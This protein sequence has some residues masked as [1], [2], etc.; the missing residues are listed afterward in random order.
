MKTHNVEPFWVV[1]KK[2]RFF[3]TFVSRAAICLAAEAERDTG[4]RPL[5]NQRAVARVATT[6]TRTR[7]N[8]HTTRHTRHETQNRTF[9]HVDHPL[10]VGNGL[11][12][13][14]VAVDE[15][16]FVDARLGAERQFI[17]T[18]AAVLHLIGHHITTNK[19]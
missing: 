7:H 11:L 16:Q 12:V 1:L 13:F 14:V 8:R 19:Q 10:A 18:V 9:E 17:R 15:A 5:G 6:R 2:N 4:V 3:S